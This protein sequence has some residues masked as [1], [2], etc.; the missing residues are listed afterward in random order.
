M[1]LR[2]ARLPRRC[3]PP[4]RIP[5]GAVAPGAVPSG[6]GGHSAGQGLALGATALKRTAGGTA[7]ATRTYAENSGFMTLVKLAASEEECSGDAAVG[8][9][10]HLCL[11][12]ESGIAQPGCYLVRLAAVNVDLHRVASVALGL[13]T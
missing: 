2:I 1:R 9:E 3:G 10:Q 5:P 4:R 6:T 8:A 12:G 13:Q 7:R 11:D